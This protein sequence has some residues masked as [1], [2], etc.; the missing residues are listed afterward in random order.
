MF[1]TIPILLAI[2]LASSAIASTNTTLHNPISPLL[3]SPSPS[4]SPALH[5]SLNTNPNIQINK[6][7]IP[8]P[9][10]KEF[11][12]L[13][14]SIKGFENEATHFPDENPTPVDAL[15]FQQRFSNVNM[16]FRTVTKL[17]KDSG[18][19]SEAD[20]VNII[21]SA[22]N[23]EGAFNSAMKVNSTTCRV[24]VLKKEVHRVFQVVIDAY[25]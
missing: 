17:V 5:T 6:K 19:L 7:R 1:K 18:S 9:L 20:S 24:A 15:A 25:A 14:A 11:P 2:L 10:F 3:P 23:M 12:K 8:P 21:S 16:E 13:V 22:E 4:P